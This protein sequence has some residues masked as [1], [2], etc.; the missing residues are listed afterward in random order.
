MK[1]MKFT[2][3]LSTFVAG[4]MLFLGTASADEADVKVRQER[5]AIEVQDQKQVMSA[6]Q[7]IG[8]SISNDQN[9]DL[10]TVKDLL[11]ST[12]GELEYIVLSE[13][14]VLGV[15]GDLIP[16]PFA[17]VQ[18][19]LNFQG[20]NILIANLTEDRVKSAPKFKEDDLASLEQGSGDVYNE[21]HAYFGQ[22]EAGRT[23]SMSQDRSM[24]KSMS[25][26]KSMSG[27]KSM[28]HDKSMTKSQSKTWNK[29]NQE[30]MDRPDVA[31]PDAT[32]KEYQRGTKEQE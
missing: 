31:D 6:D 9:Q 23:K 16:I 1:K 5:S 22:D 17:S 4:S 2:A 18:D 13:G 3:A 27:D 32:P 28:T 30:S 8:K 7:L 20:D 12:D 15:G 19:D 10:G 25:K 11:F 29:Q 24:E 21:V 14:G 26:D